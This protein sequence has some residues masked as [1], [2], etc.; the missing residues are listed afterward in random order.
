MLEKI[1]TK[2]NIPAALARAKDKS[3][4]LRLSGFSCSLP[5][6]PAILH[7]CNKHHDCR[8]QLPPHGIRS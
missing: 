7:G 5:P 3:G 2:E 4:H 8:Q 6:C 1:G